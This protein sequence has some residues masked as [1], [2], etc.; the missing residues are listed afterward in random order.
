MDSK[1]NSKIEIEY[2]QEDFDKLY[3]YFKSVLAINKTL[4]SAFMGITLTAFIF[5]L[6]L[7]YPD[8]L[9]EELIIGA[10]SIKIVPASLSILV[11][12]FFFFLTAT[13][14]YHYCELKLHSFYLY[15]G[16]K[17]TLSDRYEKSEKLYDRYYNFAFIFLFSGVVFLIAAIIFI[18][19]KFSMGGIFIAIIMLIYIVIV[20]GM[21]YLYLRIKKYFLKKKKG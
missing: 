18:F 14:L 2:S 21:I 13:F 8:I 12:S 20:I 7:G 9:E 1:T 3:K 16:S 6:S 11:L 10:I 17:L 19:L 15:W 5:L 4:S